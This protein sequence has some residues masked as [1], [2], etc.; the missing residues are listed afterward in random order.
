MIEQKEDYFEDFD[1][2]ILKEPRKEEIDHQVMFN[3]YEQFDVDFDSRPCIIPKDNIPDEFEEIIN[4]HEEIDEEELFNKSNRNNEHK[5]QRK[6][7]FSWG[8][9]NK[10]KQKRKAYSLFNGLFRQR[11]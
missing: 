1:S 6:R 4:Q 11:G 10:T 5:I 2:E 3:D 9:R 8:Y 7:N